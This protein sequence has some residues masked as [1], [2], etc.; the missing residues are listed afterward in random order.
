[1]QPQYNTVLKGRLLKCGL[2][3]KG[4]PIYQHIISLPPAW[5]DQSLA[6]SQG[7]SVIRLHL[8]RITRGLL[9]FSLQI[10][11]SAGHWVSIPLRL[12]LPPSL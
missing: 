6:S 9:R 5:Q 8:P 4:K 3:K 10:T 11:F 12:L 2:D 7:V 1:M